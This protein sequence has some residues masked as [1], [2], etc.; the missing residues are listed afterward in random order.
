MSFCEIVESKYENYVQQVIQMVTKC[1][2]LQLCHLCISNLLSLKASDL[3]T[4]S[5]RNFIWW[6]GFN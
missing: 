4:L 2:F 1:V 5:V 3:L 6:E